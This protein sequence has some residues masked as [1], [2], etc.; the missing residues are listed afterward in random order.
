[1][2]TIIVTRMKT[3]VIYR[4]VITIG[5]QVKITDSHSRFHRTNDEWLD[6]W[7]RSI[8]F[9]LLREFFTDLGPWYL[10]LMGDVCDCR[11][12]DHAQRHCGIVG[13]GFRSR[14]FPAS[15]SSSPPE[16]KEQ[17]FNSLCF[18]GCCGEGV[19]GV[20]ATFS[21]IAL[22]WRNEWLKPG[23]CTPDL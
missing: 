6:Y 11:Y 8:V 9:F 18:G 22:S 23:A 17:R 16:T 19:L 1:M 15:T 13:R 14:T 10:I 3:I 12:L 20:M 5:K 4:S 21:A 7:I 2:T